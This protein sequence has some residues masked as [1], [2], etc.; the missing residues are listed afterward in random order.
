MSIKAHIARM[1]ISMV[2]GV[3]ALGALA[4]LSSDWLEESGYPA[5]LVFFL[6]IHV[7][8]IVPRLMFAFVFRAKCPRCGSQALHKAELHPK[9]ICYVC[10][11]CGYSE[12]TI[13][14]QGRAVP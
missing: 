1:I 7:G 8:W 6:A 12:K 11:A 4:A 13:W 5:G 9:P 14:T 10:K 3:V 2:I